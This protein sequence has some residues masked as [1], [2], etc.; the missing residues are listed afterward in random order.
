MR[1]ARGGDT[2]PLNVGRVTACDPVRFINAR[3]QD[4]FSGYRDAA[5]RSV[6]EFGA[7]N[8]GRFFDLL[9]RTPDADI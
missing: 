6:P 1:R 3:W 9:A 2:S 4:G 5:P 7:G 8:K